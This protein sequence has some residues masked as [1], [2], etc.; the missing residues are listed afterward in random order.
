[1]AV[2]TVTGVN[3]AS[4]STRGKNV[5]R[6]EGTNFRLPDPPPLTGEVQSEQ[7]KTV[8]VQFEG[9]ESEWAY[10]ASDSLILARV[11]TWNGPY[12]ITFPAQL[13]VRVANLDNSGVEIPGENATLADAYSINRPSLQNESYL[14]RVVREVIRLFR[15]HVLENTHHTTSRDFSLSPATQETLRAEGPLVQLGGPS[16][17][18]NRF[19]TI[20]RETVEE[21]PLGGV[22]GRMRRK[23][24]VT[25]DMNFLTTV[26]ANNIYHLEG[27]VQALLLFQ[28]DIKLVKVPR[29]PTNPAAGTKDYE[30]RMSWDSYPDINSDPTT[31]DLMYAA[32]TFFVRGVHIDE[33]IGTIVE[34]G[35]IITQ[36]NGD[37]VLQVQ[38]H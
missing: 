25:V 35:W 33:D 27:L 12:D 6:I 4:G 22:D 3:P 7:Q 34:R 37:P 14:Q 5:I 36:N 10:S 17:V 2:P 1:M 9:E 11:P 19:H 16:L 31:D 18:L 23:P 28:R 20:E 8:S 26:W 29:D 21:D 24:P 13:D 32:A 30:F 38:S 15:R